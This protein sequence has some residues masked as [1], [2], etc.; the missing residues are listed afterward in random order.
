MSGTEYPKIETLYDRDPQTFRVVPG[1]YRLAE[2]ALVDRWLVTEKVDGTNVRIEFEIPT[3][4]RTLTVIRYKGRTD[5]A[6]MPTFLYEHLAATFDWDTITRAFE[7]GTSGVLY[8]EGYGP[9]IQKGGGNYRT[10]GPSFRLF[11]VKVGDWWLNWDGVEDVARKLGIETVPVLSR[12]AT[13]AEAAK[14]HIG[15]GAVSQVALVEHDGHEVA[16]EGIVAR[17]DPLLFTRKGQRLMWKIKG[18]DF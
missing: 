4:N 10:E 9:K 17:T 13:L 3:A 5:A 8:G 6:Q 14:N 16:P 12:D 2:F 11:D 15:S 1:Q 18:R 7:P